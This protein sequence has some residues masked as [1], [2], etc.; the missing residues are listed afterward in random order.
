MFVVFG[1]RSCWASLFPIRYRRVVRPLLRF[2]TAGDLWSI[3]R[4]TQ[5]SPRPWDYLLS[6]FM[7]LAWNFEDFPF[8]LQ[9]SNSYIADPIVEGLYIYIWQSLKIPRIFCITSECG[10]F[11]VEPGIELLRLLE[12]YRPMSLDL[13]SSALMPFGFIIKTFTFYKKSWPSLDVRS[14]FCIFIVLQFY[15]VDC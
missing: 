14:R 10:F 12:D 6:L 1:F 11:L 15:N 5:G 2:R 3:R 7:F 4:P 9:S 13:L 8:P